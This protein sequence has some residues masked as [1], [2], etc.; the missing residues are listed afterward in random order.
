MLKILQYYTFLIILTGLVPN[1]H[2]QKPEKIKYKAEQLVYEKKKGQEPYRRLT[3]HVIFTQENTT[4][5]C[6][7]SFFYSTR[8]VMESFG[9]VRILDDSAVITSKK[10]NYLG[11]ERMAELREKVV[12]RRGTRTLYTD[13]LDYDLQNKIAHYFNNG[14]L[15][16]E[17]NTLTSK[18]GYYYSQREYAEFYGN[19]VL[20]APEYVL[21]ADTLYYNT[22]TKVANTVGP[23][24][25]I[26]KDGTTLY[27]DGSE[28]RTVIDQS[29]FI[30]GKIET[31]EYT[32]DGEK[33]YFDDLKKYYRAV[34]NV[35]MTSKENDVIIT[36]DEAFYDKANGISKVYGHPLMKKVMEEDTFYL[37][38]DTLVALESDYDSAKRILAYYHVKFYQ[39]TIQGLADSMAYF[40]SDSVL[41]FYKDPLMWNNQNQIEGDTINLEIVQEQVHKMNIMTNAFL[42]SEDSIKDYN[43]VKGRQMEGFFVDNEITRINV[44]GNGEVLY[45]A[46]EKGDSILMGMNKIF[47]AT[48]KML[49]EEQKIMS[50][51]VYTEPEAQFIPP[52]E[53]TSEIIRLTNFSWR[54]TER[55]ELY[56]LAP[57]LDPNYDPNAPPEEIKEDSVSQDT[58]SLAP[59]TITPESSPKPP[60]I[61]ELKQRRKNNTGSSSDNGNSTS[62][63]NM[64]KGLKNK[65][66]D[67]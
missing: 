30:D 56:D 4:V 62:A 51:T 6:D 49:F 20:E 55:P 44:D 46:L 59:P 57:Y 32:I 33:L 37:K 35:V 7:T 18:I 1:L 40:R 47:C 22:L 29:D 39:K 38:A 48:M 24:V 26:D 58:A 50:L 23:T 54:I 36:G 66:D 31:E 11:N 19:V 9:H 52:Q 65:K 45:F 8:N 13:F 3:D 63:P 60:N 16:D 14:K 41:Y 12:Y 67:D 10:L 15:V 5:Y 17:S 21:K 61:S 25:I 43:Q 64:M 42:I 28:F 53:L 27:A 2:G 34:T